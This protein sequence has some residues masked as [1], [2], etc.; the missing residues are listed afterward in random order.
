MRPKAQS[1]VSK[2]DVHSDK[3]KVPRV[4]ALPLLHLLAKSWVEVEELGTRSVYYLLGY[5][6]FSIFQ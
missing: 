2:G 1:P 3:R 4:T 5:G 6:M